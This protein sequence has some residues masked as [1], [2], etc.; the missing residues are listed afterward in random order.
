[1]ALV[2]RTGESVVAKVYPSGGGDITY[3]NMQELWHS[4][5]GERRRQPGLPRPID[6]LPQIGVLIMERLPGRPLIELG[7]WDE[8]ILAN[9][10]RLVA[11]LHECDA[12]PS[13]RRDSPGIVR[14]AKRMAKRVAELAPHFA[15]A[16][17]ELAE[18]LEA[19]QVEDLELVPSHGD[20]SPRNVLVGSH[21]LTLIDWDRF[22]RADP[23]RDITHMGT[24]CWFCALRQGRAPDWLVLDRLIET[25][26]LLRPGGGIEARLSFHVAAGLMRIA[27]SWA[28]FW[29]DEAHLVPPLITEA[30]R[31]LQ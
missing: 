26:N 1:M 6:Y 21:R 20:F 29:P 27:H 14:S 5:F 3:A 4:S 28:R 31:Q 9:A 18:A 10:V 2:T 8:D 11:S 12:E 7:T 24:W 23:A 19:A 16:F 15:E 25:Y 13:Q 22:Q 30:L 17:R